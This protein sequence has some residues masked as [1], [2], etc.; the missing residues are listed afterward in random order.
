MTEVNASVP[1]PD[2]AIGTD[3]AMPEPG[4]AEEAVPL[5]AFTPEETAVLVLWEEI[6]STAHL[7][8]ITNDSAALVLILGRIDTVARGVSAFGKGG[9]SSILST[10]LG[11]SGG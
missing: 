2:D 8:N 4:Q 3:G 11:G 10:L 6:E 1:I 7:L 9:F 5:R